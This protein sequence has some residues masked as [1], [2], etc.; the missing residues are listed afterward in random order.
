VINNTPFIEIGE[1][2]S[3]KRPLDVTIRWSD[4]GHICL[5]RVWLT[6]EEMTEYLCKEIPELLEE[7]ADE[8]RKTYGTS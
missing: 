6:N 3:Q 8:W 1:E 2:P 7:I 5:A 4:G